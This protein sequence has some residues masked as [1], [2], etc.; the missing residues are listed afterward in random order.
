MQTNNRKVKMQTNK[1]NISDQAFDLAKSV[2]SASRVANLYGKLFAI[3]DMQIHLLEQEKLIKDQ[4]ES[5]ER[6]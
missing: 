2:N 3:K 4:L 5:E 6:K 1:N